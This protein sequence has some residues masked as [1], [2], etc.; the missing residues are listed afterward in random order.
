MG[1]RDRLER[2]IGIAGMLTYRYTVSQKAVLARDIIA[3]FITLYLVYPTTAMIV[4]PLL[5]FVPEHFLGHKL[6]FTS[7]D[8]LGP[9]WFQI[10]VI[11]LSVSFFCYSMHRLQH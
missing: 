4:L 11:A 10:L 8:Q 7:P 1:D 6:V 5:T 9:F 2:L 3:T